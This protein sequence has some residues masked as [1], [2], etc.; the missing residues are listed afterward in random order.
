MSSTSPALGDTYTL[1]ELPRTPGLLLPQRVVVAESQREKSYMGSDT[2]EV[3]I[4]KSIIASYVLKPTPKLVWSY[5]LSPST[6][7][8]SMDVKNSA[9]QLYAIG[10]TERSKSRLLLLE[11]TKDDTVVTAELALSQ[12]AI[13]VKFSPGKNHIYVLLRNGDFAIAEYNHGTKSPD[14]NGAPDASDV[15][16]TPQ[17]PELT[18]ELTDSQG[19]VP[20]ISSK[21]TKVDF[22]S[23][24]P[25]GSFNHKSDLLFYAVRRSKTVVFRLI[26]LNGTKSFEI[27]QV[28]VAAPVS[29]LKPSCTY[30]QGMLYVYDSETRTITSRSLMKPQEILKSVSV[31]SLVDPATEKDVMSLVAVAADRLLL[32]YKSSVFLINFKYESL[33]SEHTNNSGNQVFL[34]F[35]LPVEGTSADSARSFALYLNL[36]EKTNSCKLKSIQVDVGVNV[37][38]ESLGKSLSARTKPTGSVSNPSKPGWSGLPHLDAEDLVKD[39]GQSLDQLSAVYSKLEKH[40]A[41]KNTNEFDLCVVGF[42]KNDK[43][44]KLG[45]KHQASL[46]FSA[47]SDRVVDHRFIESV[48]GLILSLDEKNYVQ[49]ID[50]GF[51]PSTSLSYLL[52]HP[53]FPVKYTRGLL[54]LLS[55]LDQPELLKKAIEKCRA[56]TLDELMTEFTN[57]T[58]VSEELDPKNKHEVAFVAEFLRVTIDRI[59]KDYSL[60][61]ITSKLSE[62]LTNEYETDSKKL[63][64]MLN[65]LINV[66]TNSSWTLVQAVID[67][68]G[69]FNWTVPTIVA[70]SEVIDAKVD[71][72]ASNT[73]NLTLTNQALIAL[74]QKH[75]KRSKKTEPKVVDNIHEIANQRAQLEAILTISN[76]TTNKKLMA[77]EDI[78]L[79]KQIPTYSREKLI[80]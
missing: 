43:V 11:K 54:V 19:N 51:L 21:A 58:E 41:K 7:V 70:L 56:L 67:V 17:T 80:F 57:L 75:Q 18:V 49:I 48:I 78:E 64:R 13:A 53:L 1:M 44:P 12:P 72:L 65:V 69:L 79:A 39:N 59:L 73:Y 25:K 76:N 20:N 42:L 34:D 38:S 8:D 45:K 31:E 62:V 66:N 4:S 40:K 35:A 33:L 6:V 68:G 74:E 60:A 50:E 27:Y 47:S 46:G 37:L 30:T 36:E 9:T 32:S 61:Q 77:D 14:T 63:E 10:L 71:A 26:A 5:P 2:I 52:T 24:I 28:S 22:H 29:S 16:Q 15:S 3:G 55:A 23:F